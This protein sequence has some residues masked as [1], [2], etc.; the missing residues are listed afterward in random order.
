MMNETDL[1][2][3]VTPLYNSE[4]YIEET[5]KNVQNQTYE[6]WEWLL[7]NDCSTDRSTEIVEKY[8]KEDKRIKLLNLKENSGAATARN[9]GIEQ[10]K[11][12]YIAFLDSDDLWV[13]EKLE[14]QIKFAKKN[15]YD[16]TFTDY[17]F[18][19]ETGKPTGKVVKVPKTINY[20]QALKN[21][22]IFTSTV[23]FNVKTLGKE[24]IFMPDVQRGQDTATWWKVLKTGRTAYALNESL[25]FYRRSSNTL[26]SNKITALKRTWNLYRNVEKLSFFTALYNFCWYCFNAVKRRI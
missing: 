11:G 8:A 12:K 20:K 15:N 1:I 25:S 3:I 22:T 26:S 21:T 17:E 13:K 5:I 6:N 23:M 7:V 9:V 14:K 10:S 16:F 4:K 18:A 2:S 19:D 24:L